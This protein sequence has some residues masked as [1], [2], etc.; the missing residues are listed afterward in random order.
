[1]EEHYEQTIDRRKSDCEILIE[2]QS[3]KRL[4]DGFNPKFHEQER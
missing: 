3:R 2:M 4:L 1:M